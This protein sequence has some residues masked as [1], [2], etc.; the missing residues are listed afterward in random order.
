MVVVLDGGDGGGSG[1]VVGGHSVVFKTK[2]KQR[3]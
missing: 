3:H 1:T 2:D